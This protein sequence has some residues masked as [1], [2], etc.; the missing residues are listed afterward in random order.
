MQANHEFK[1]RLGYTETLGLK[2]PTTTI[3]NLY[4]KHS[5]MAIFSPLQCNMCRTPPLLPH[6]I[7]LLSQFHRML[8]FSSYLNN[9]IYI[10]FKMY[11]TYFF[12]FQ[13]FFFLY[14]PSIPSEKVLSIAK[15]YRLDLE[16][17][18]EKTLR[19]TFQ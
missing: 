14:Y 16:F 13:Y 5:L 15:L 9:H 8:A 11:L 4:P 10:F 3:L 6:Q 19:L 18:V 1:A 12:A 17:P 7:L 2:T